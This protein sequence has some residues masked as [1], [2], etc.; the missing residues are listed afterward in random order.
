LEI[1]APALNAPPSRTPTAAWSDEHLV[2]EC[3]RGNQQAWSA[4]VDKYKHLVYSAP[5]KYR[6]S[7]QDT[8][9]VFQEVWLDLYSELEE[10]APTARSRRMAGFRGFPQVLPVEAAPPP[11]SRTAA[12]RIRARPRSA[13]WRALGHVSYAGSQYEE[14]LSHYQKALEILTALGRDLEDARSPADSSR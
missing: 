3:L 12:R 10:T 4:V 6:M 14:A 7:P 13:G 11:G 2:E 9:D 5:I 1:D 8:A